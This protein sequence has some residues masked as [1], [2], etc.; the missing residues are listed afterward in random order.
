MKKLL[1]IHLHIEHT[2]DGQ[3]IQEQH[4][5]FNVV[6]ETKTMFIYKR[7]GTDSKAYLQ[8]LNKNY[9]NSIVGNFECVQ[10]DD[11]E[12]K[13][14]L[15]MSVFCSPEDKDKYVKLIRQ[16]M[17]KQSLS[18]KAMVDKFCAVYSHNEILDSDTPYID[19]T[20]NSEITV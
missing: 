6:R 10:T 18:V 13:N 5:M 4:T 1:R 7:L 15:N 14:I 20:E 9:L 8:V 17:I 11:L 3:N 2:G 19:V 16:N 12:Y